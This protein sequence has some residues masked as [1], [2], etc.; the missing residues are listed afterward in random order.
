[1]KAVKKLAL[2][3]SLG[4]ILPFAHA[5]ESADDAYLAA[6]R[7]DPGVPVPVAVVTPRISSDFAGSTVEV[8]FTVDVAGKPVNLS[9]VSAVDTELSDSVLAAIKQWRFQP[10]VRDGAPVATKVVLPVRIVEPTVGS[11]TY[12]MN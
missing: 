11:G 5:A 2:V 10:A 12:A 1:M 8:A 4:A 6:C 9:V 7:K 3:L